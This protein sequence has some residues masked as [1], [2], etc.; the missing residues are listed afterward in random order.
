MVVGSYTL[1]RA[2]VAKLRVEVQPAVPLKDAVDFAVDVLLAEHREH[3]TIGKLGNR[4]AVLSY[5]VAT[6]ELLGEGGAS[7][8]EAEFNELRSRVGVHPCDLAVLQP[9]TRER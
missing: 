7:T 5:R 4:D 1:S 3:G 8:L 9:E 6:R 2:R